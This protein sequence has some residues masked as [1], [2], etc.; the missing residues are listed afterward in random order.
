MKAPTADSDDDVD[1]DPDV[2]IEPHDPGM[3]FAQFNAM[4]QMLQ[5]VQGINWS[6]LVQ[7]Q[8]QGADANLQINRG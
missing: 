1:S 5:V 2:V 4:N 6:P 8:N 3:A 7:E